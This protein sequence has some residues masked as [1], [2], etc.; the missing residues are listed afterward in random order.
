VCDFG[1]SVFL[2]LLN[3]CNFNSGH[4]RQWR[5]A[6]AT[7]PWTCGHSAGLHETG[8]EWQ[9]FFASESQRY[10][11]SHLQPMTVQLP[12]AFEYKK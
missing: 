5:R 3:K 12:L 1:R 8:M 7:T 10:L 2:L 11:N 4:L 6:S 9:L